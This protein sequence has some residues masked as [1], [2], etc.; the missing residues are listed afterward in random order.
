MRCLGY[1]KVG[2]LGHLKGRTQETEEYSG[3]Q[4]QLGRS[5]GNFV[6]RSSR[7][8]LEDH[9]QP[10]LTALILY[11][12]VT[13]FLHRPSLSCRLLHLRV[14][15]ALCL[16]GVVQHLSTRLIVMFF[17]NITRN[18]L[19]PW[20]DKAWLVQEVSTPRGCPSSACQR[21]QP[22]QVRVSRA[23]RPVMC[24]MLPMR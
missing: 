19:L 6:T 23:V 16:P 24:R 7:S 9:R 13:H 4:I 8:H 21:C 5:G 22:R 12:T 18:L 3:H 15:A 1:S 20:P 10:L 17:L 11:M 14:P 2:V